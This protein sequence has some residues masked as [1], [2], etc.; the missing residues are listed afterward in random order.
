MYYLLDLKWYKK[1][2]YMRYKDVL[3][4]LYTGYKEVLFIIYKEVL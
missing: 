2:L 4:V 1:V 3:F